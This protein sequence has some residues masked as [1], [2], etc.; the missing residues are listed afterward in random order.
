MLEDLKKAI[1]SL[2]GTA[3]FIAVIGFLSSIVTV[4]VNTS[5]EVSVKWLLLSII[6]GLYATVILLK[7]A[8]DVREKGRPSPPFENPIR[9]VADPG[10]FVIRKNEN[11]LANILVA[12]Y[13]QRD[14]LDRLAYIGVVEHIQPS[15]I[16]IRIQLDL[17]VLPSIPIGPDELKML[18]IRPVVP[19]AALQQL[20]IQEA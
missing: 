1:F 17:L 3:I 7:V 14:G 5:A 10:I 4:F 9:F 19:F 16:Q 12:C 13:S 11:F 6:I 8:H 2:N 15:I 18:E 20:T